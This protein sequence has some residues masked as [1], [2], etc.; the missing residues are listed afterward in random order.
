V[1]P[2]VVGLLLPKAKRKIAKAHCRTGQIARRASSK[3]LKGHVL[4]QKP[5]PRKR[6]RAGAKVNLTVGRGPRRR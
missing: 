4:A 6:L 2:R 3:R 1:V 5:A